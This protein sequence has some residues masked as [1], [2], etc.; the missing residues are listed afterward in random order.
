[1]RDVVILRSWSAGLQKPFLWNTAA[2]GALFSAGLV[3]SKSVKAVLVQ[4]LIK[5]EVK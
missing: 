1:M 3:Q 2:P 5:A 4:E